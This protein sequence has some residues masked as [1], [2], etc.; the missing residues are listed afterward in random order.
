MN[1]SLTAVMIC[2]CLLSACQ[3]PTDP[4]ET[5]DVDDILDLALSPSPAVATEAT[6]GRTYRV[7][8]GNNQPDEILPF[9]WTTTFTVTATLNSNANDEDANV[10]FPVDIT[11]VAVVVKQ[12]SGGIVT[13]PSGGETEHFFYVTEA[14]ANRYASANSSVSIRLDVWYDLPSL[15]REALITVTMNFQDNDGQ[16]FSKAY[17]VRVAP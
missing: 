12:A 10:E 14:S 17:D 5:L 7:V 6:D 9:D 15:R 8:R 3:S 1:R 4:D 11:S 13:P 2:V 16:S